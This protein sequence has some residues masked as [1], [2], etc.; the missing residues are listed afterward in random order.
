MSQSIPAI[1]AALLLV[2]AAFALTE[3]G[4]AQGAIERQAACELSAIRETR[5]PLAVQLIRSACN[6]LALNSGS[7]LN[8]RNRNYYACLVQNLSGVQSDVAAQAIASA[9]RASNPL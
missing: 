9:C 3:S 7:L 1:I 2:G 5:S 4:K 6:W 8:E